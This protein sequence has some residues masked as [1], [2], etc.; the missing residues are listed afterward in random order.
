[1]SSVLPS[2]CPSGTLV[3]CDQIGWNSSEII[4][5]LVSLR[6]SLSAD[7]NIRGLLQG[8][9]AEILAQSDQ[10][11][12]WFESRRHSIANCGRMV[13]DSATVTM[14]SLYRKPPLLFR[15]VPSLI[16]YDLPFPPKWGSIC[17]Q[18]TRMAISPQPVVRSTSCLVI[19]R[20][21]RVRRI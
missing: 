3:G 15:M 8:E 9:H 14:E 21:F 17:P 13:T 19:G 7:L 4:P 12:C 11:P 16:P 20:G 5:P 10:P 6:C 2:V 18:H 1:M